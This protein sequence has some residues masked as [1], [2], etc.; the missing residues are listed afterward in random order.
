M[1]DIFVVET[2]D[3]M[4]YCVHIADVT[5]ELIPQAL[6]CAGPLHQ[7][8]NIEEFQCRRD[9]LFGMDEI[10]DLVQSFVR[11]GNDTNIGLNGCKPIRRHFSSRKGQSIE[12]GGLPHIG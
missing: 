9:H 2:P 10:G 7:S 6:P 3:D 1:G 12:D 11:N 4:G 5:E 8:S